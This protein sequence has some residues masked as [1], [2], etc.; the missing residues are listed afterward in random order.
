MEQPKGFNYAILNN[1]TIMGV[2]SLVSNELEPYI[3]K[4]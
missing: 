1:L 3:K 2:S 4:K